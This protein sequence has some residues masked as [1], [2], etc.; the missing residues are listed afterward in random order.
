MRQFKT[1]SL[2]P[3]N[4]LL[5]IFYY[6]PTP[7]KSI[8]PRLILQS[9]F[10]LG[11]FFLASL[12]NCH[13]AGRGQ[14]LHSTLP[15][16]LY[17]LCL[18]EIFTSG[19]TTIEIILQIMGTQFSWVP[20]RGSVHVDFSLVRWRELKKINRCQINTRE[21]I[22][23]HGLSKILFIGFDGIPVSKRGDNEWTKQAKL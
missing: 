22:P 10:M 2:A 18:E 7:Q 21:V 13:R 9:Q 1:G 20:P 16:M 17:S 3:Y 15:H 6:Q 5:T 12:E 11:R 8:N 4:I 14:F 19:T 23:T